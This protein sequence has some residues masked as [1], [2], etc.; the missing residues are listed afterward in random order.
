MSLLKI[1]ISGINKNRRKRLGSTPK[2]SSKQNIYTRFLRKLLRRLRISYSKNIQTVT[3]GS[4]GLWDM[5]S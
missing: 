5:V 4:M 1:C 2:G 3:V